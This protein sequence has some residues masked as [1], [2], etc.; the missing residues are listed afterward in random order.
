MIEICG[1]LDKSKTCQ[2]DSKSIFSTIYIYISEH[3][4]THTHIYIYNNIYIY[5]CIYSY[6]A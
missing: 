6:I 1:K 3:T 4:H 5:I 2:I